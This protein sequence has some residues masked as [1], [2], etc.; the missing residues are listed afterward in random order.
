MIRKIVVAI[1]TIFLFAVMAWATVAASPSEVDEQQIA[2]MP[3]EYTLPYPGILPDNPLYPIKTLRDKIVSFFITDAKKQAQFDLL[4]ADK[5]LVAGEYLLEEQHPASDLIS[6]TISKGQNYFA[7]AITNV[8]AAKT[9]GQLVNDFINTLHDA[10]IKHEQILI[11]MSDKTQGQLH[12][13]LET[14]IVRMQGFENQV[15]KLATE[16]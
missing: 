16:K 3:V 7:D 1:S 8:T 12:K 13:D 15:K 5:R 9:Q 6:E 2:H 4:Q 14:D 10:G 11:Q